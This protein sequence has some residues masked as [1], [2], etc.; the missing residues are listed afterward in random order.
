M[1]T[2]THTRP[3]GPR[4]RGPAACGSLCLA[5]GPP[6]AVGRQGKTGLSSSRRR[7]RSLAI[8]YNQ[9][10]TENP[11]APRGGHGARPPLLGPCARRAIAAAVQ[12]S[13]ANVAFLRR[14]LAINRAS[15]VAV[16]E[17]AVAEAAGVHRFEVGRDSS[18]GH[19]SRAGAL[20]VRTLM[21]DDLMSRG[22]PAPQVIK[23][24]IEG[25]ELAALRGARLLLE[26]H[27]PAIFLATHGADVHR[28]C[29]S[30]FD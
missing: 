16:I 30:L 10:V 5:H 20:E 11:R 3:T 8:S 2:R 28:A 27:R 1:G 24:D 18:A 26:R 22:T 23:M 12:P 14:H 25:G 15:N 6:T 4:G 9:A 17:A 7:C 21:L 13:P 19:L 29:C